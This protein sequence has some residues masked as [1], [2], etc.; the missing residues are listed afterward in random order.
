MLTLTPAHFTDEHE[1]H[2]MKGQRV[3]GCFAHLGKLREYK[4]LLVFIRRTDKG[5]RPT[6]QLFHVWIRRIGRV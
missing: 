5:Q 2:R 1:T 3:T 6:L 4:L